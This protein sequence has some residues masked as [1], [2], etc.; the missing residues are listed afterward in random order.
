[1]LVIGPGLFSQGT[2]L[3]V[4]SPFWKGLEIRFETRIE[5]AGTRL[6]GGIFTGPDRAHHVINDAAHRRTFGYDIALDAAEDGQTAQIRIERL[7]LPDS[8]LPRDGWTLLG[9]PKYPV[10]PHVK[11]GETVAL[12][13]LVNPST[14]QKVVD[15]L[16]LQRRGSMDLSRPPH[17]FS[18]ADVEL[19]LMEPQ[20]FLNGK[21]EAQDS[22]GGTAGAVVWFYLPGRGRFILSLIPN[23]SLGFVKNGV[24]SGNGLLFRD[25]T[26]E[27]RVECTR[28]IAPASGTYNLYVRPQRAWRPGGAGASFLTGSADRADLVV[29]KK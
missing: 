7:T 8:K 5:P 2:A 25:G 19:T 4:S 1:M 24:V 29:G 14:G 6:P 21:P 20:V 3:T 28:G 17:D 18:L 15:Y 10:I 26:E 23:E 27:F 13:L 16:T 9:L 22:S 12:D 11:V